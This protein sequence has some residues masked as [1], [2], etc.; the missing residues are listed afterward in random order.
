MLSIS[1]YLD[2]WLTPTYRKTNVE[3]LTAK[4]A[5]VSYFDMVNSPRATYRLYD[6]ENKKI[7]YSRDVCFD[8]QCEDT[9]KPEQNPDKLI[10]VD[11][12]DTE[13]NDNEQYDCEQPSQLQ[14]N[15]PPQLRRSDRTRRPPLVLWP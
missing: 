2:V 7:I 11:S 15:S 14:A 3:N 10:S 9:S 12:D 6:A 5:N 13:D 8:E 4:L 1:K